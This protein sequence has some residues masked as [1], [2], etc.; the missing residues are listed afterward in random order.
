MYKKLFV[1]LFVAATLIIAGQ[2]NDATSRITEKIVIDMPVEEENR[3]VPHIIDYQGH[4]TDTMGVPLNGT[5]EFIFKICDAETSGE[6]LWSETQA[7]VIITNGIFS[8]LLGSITPIPL[9]VFSNGT[10]RWLELTVDGQTLA[11]RTRISTV[12]YAYIATHADTAEY[13]DSSHYADTAGYALAAQNNGLPSGYGILGLSEIA[14]LGYTY[15]GIHVNAAD[16]CLTD[17]WKELADMPTARFYHVVAEVNE[18]LYAIGGYYDGSILNVNEEYD[19]STNT[20]TTKTSM[21]TARYGPAAAAVNGKIYVIGGNDTGN[22]DVVEEYD[23]ATDTWATKTIMPTA[24]YNL[25]AAV[26]NNKIYAI[27][28]GNVNEEY[29]PATDTW[30]TKANGPCQPGC[31]A[32]AYNGKIYMIGGTSDRTRNCEYDPATDSW[33]YKAPLIV[34]HERSVC[35]AVNGKIHSVSGTPLE[36]QNDAYDPV[37]DTWT[38]KADMPTGRSW[39]AGVALNGKIYVIGGS[40]TAGNKNE[41]YTP[42]AIR[43][44]FH[45]KN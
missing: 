20:W 7:N 13:A 39:A 40:G 9:S 26:V 17:T 35:A 11:P 4:V 32:A 31:A 38:A 3:E 23:P 29:D 19:P 8:A 15:S 2:E 14:P 18:K 16:T 37:T 22:L 36:D 34:G 42:D 27:G 5:Y 33:T 30:T 44:H 6:E 28:G 24:R 10:S 45:V 21:P 12:G 1:V 43:L 25:C 41:V